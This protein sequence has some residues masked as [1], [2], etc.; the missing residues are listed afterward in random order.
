MVVVTGET[1]CVPLVALVPVQPFDAVQDV[2]FVELFV[3]ETSAGEKV[4]AP[5]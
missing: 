4:F 3:N 1:L 5:V 2:A